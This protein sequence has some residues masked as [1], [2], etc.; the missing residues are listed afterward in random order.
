MNVCLEA[1]SHLRLLRDEVSSSETCDV[2]IEE[3]VF[4]L[5]GLIAGEKR[6]FVQNKLNDVPSENIMNVPPFVSGT[7]QVQ[8]K[9]DTKSMASAARAFQLMMALQD[10]GDIQVMTPTQAEAR[11]SCWARFRRSAWTCRRRTRLHRH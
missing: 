7:I 4:L 9:I 1:V 2:D 5:K 10:I 8:A 11:V 6:E 3:I